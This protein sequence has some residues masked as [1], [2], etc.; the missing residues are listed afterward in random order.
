[1]LVNGAW[2]LSKVLKTKAMV[3]MKSP[4]KANE[5]PIFARFSLFEKRKEK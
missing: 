5:N 3:W 2:P 4:I 1:M